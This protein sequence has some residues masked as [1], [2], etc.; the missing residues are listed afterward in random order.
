MTNNIVNEINIWFGESRSGIHL[1]ER[2]TRKI[3]QLVS[4]IFDSIDKGMKAALFATGGYGRGELC[5]YSDIDIMF[6][7]PDRTDTGAAEMMLYRLWDTGFEIS[8]SFRTPKEC[9]EEA[10]K[11]MRTRTSL[12]EARYVAGDRSL[13]DMFRSKV[14][15]EIVYRK[16]KDF[17]RE[18]LLEMERR[19]L[20][21]GESVFL[22][23]PHVKEG[24]GGLR[25]V[26]TSYWLSKVARKLEDFSGFSQLLS[27]NEYRRFIGAYDFLLRCRFALHLES[28]R[29]N[30]VLSFE[31]QKGVAGRLGFRDTAK[32]TATERFMRYYHLKSRIIRETTRRI[33]ADCSRSYVPFFRD[34]RVKKVGD[35][36]ALS[37]GK[38]VVSRDGLFRKEPDKVMEA[39]SLFAKTGK[40]F[41]DSTREKIV[42]ALIR[43][44]DRVRHSPAAVHCFL[45]ILRGPRVYETLREM[46]ETGVLGRFI[47]EFGALRML[48]VHEPYHMYTVDEHTLI[49]IRNLERLRATKYKNLEDF[50]TII[51]EMERID[52]LFMAILFHD[53][54]KAAGRHHEEEGYK[55]LKRIME[56]FNLD[57]KKRRRIE[58]LVKNHILM[59]RAALRMEP[60]DNEVVAMFADAVGDAENLKAIY[61]ITYAD[62]SAVNPEF[63]NSWKA[64]LLKELYVNTLAYLSGVREGRGEYL[65]GLRDACPKGELSGLLDFIAEMPERYLL[66][67]TRD[68]VLQDYR[69]VQEMKETGFSMRIDSGPGEIA[70][71]SL[72]TEDRPGLF[73]DIVGFLSSRGLNIVNGRIFTG[74]KGVVID[75]ISVSN[76][77]DVWW[78][79]LEADLGKGLKEVILGGQ[80]FATGGRRL[81]AESPFDIFIELDNEA[82]EEFTLLEIFS[83]DRLGLLYDIANVLHR[84]GADI[85]S[86][87]IN[88]EAGLAQD[89]FYVQRDKAKIEYRKA[90]EILSELWTTLKGRA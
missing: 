11:D 85:I 30:D 24:E 61:L 29:K 16:Q 46:Q 45:E 72:S 55:R 26:H 57:V 79:G 80:P 28:M 6:F 87:R 74:R 88:T 3:D 69:L 22:L 51:K 81:R 53:I 66:A 44:N 38:I 43:I 42:S 12:L 32:F 59:S 47:P 13:Y 2:Y 27:A 64:Y 62:M 52:T 39:F 14:Y 50:H 20:S 23:E 5:P 65:D 68:R 83:P 60:S 4:S 48:V 49:A 71:L 17:V 77:K 67:S 78:E 73:A 70:E 1:A 9:I 36:F 33:M 21:S 63:W 37:G 84:L 40:K 86:A 15:P 19:H 89:I 34:W 90:Q 10:F 75:K 56:R 76:W 7:A 82:F 18:K 54:G 58:F 25:D 41:S 8:H 35:D 31:Y